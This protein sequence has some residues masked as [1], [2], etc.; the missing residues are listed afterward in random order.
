MIVSDGFSSSNSRINK[1]LMEFAM[2][3]MVV[4]GSLLFKIVGGHRET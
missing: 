2:S 3:K 4:I 1:Q